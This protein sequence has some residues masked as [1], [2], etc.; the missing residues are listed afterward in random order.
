MPCLGLPPFLQM[1][2]KAMVAMFQCPASGHPH[3]YMAKMILW[4]SCNWVSMPCLGPPPFLRQGRRLH[5]VKEKRFNALPRATPIST[6]PSQIPAKIRASRTQ[7]WGVIHRIF[8]KQ[9]FSTEKMACS[10]FIHNYL[11]LSYHNPSQYS[12]QNFHLCSAHAQLPLLFIFAP[13][14]N[15]TAYALARTCTV[16]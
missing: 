4:K 1:T 5:Q 8:W 7:F 2:M 12:T 9:G 13:S 3:F 15:A 16:S 14:V 11:S 10:Q 6:L